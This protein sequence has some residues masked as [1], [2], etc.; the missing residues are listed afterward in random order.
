[1]QVGGEVYFLRGW[2]KFVDPDDT[3]KTWYWKES[4]GEATWEFPRHE[5][6]PV[7]SNGDIPKGWEVFID[8]DGD[9]WWYNDIL[10]FYT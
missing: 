1:M 4:S 6:E 8:E 7:L 2:S 10:N 9:Y 3:R 5:A